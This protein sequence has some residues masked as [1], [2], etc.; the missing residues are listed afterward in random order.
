VM[1]CRAYDIT[2]SILCYNFYIKVSPINMTYPSF[3]LYFAPIINIAAIMTC[4][5]FLLTVVKDL[6]YVERNQERA[7][8]K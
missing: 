6:E 1:T 3:A 5:F 4:Y 2:K 8:K 7:K